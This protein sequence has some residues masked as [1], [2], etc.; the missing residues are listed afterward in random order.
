MPNTSPE[1]KEFRSLVLGLKALN[2]SWSASQIST[3]LRQS[4]NPPL[5]KSRQLL[6]KVK[7]T[8]TRNTI[9][10]RQRPGRPITISTPIF[11]Q[12]VKTSMRLKRGASIR[13]VTANLNRNGT[14]CSTYTVYKAA[15]KLKL[16]WFK[17]R[18][19]QKLSYQ[20]KIDRVDCAKRLRS[21]FGVSRNAKKWKWDR[22]VN[23]DFSGVFILQP[24][25]NNRNDGIWAEENEA[26]PSS[27]INAP[28]DK[29]KKGIIFW[30]AISSN[31]L[32]PVDAPISLTKWLHEKQY[33]VKKN[34]K[35][36][37]TGDLYSKFLIEEAAPAI[38][39]VFENSGATPIFQD[40]QDNKH[41]TTLVKNI[42]ADLFDER[43]DPK[44]GDA[45]FADIWPIE[46][47]W[48][49]I[50]EKVRGQEFDGEVYLEE[51]VAVYWKTFTAEKCRQMMEKIPK[52]LKLVIDKNGE[53]IFND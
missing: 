12:Q 2:S 17:T 34:K 26:I 14:R 53:Q 52:Q 45:K 6:T 49:A 30:G 15:R 5:L 40:D 33:H 43:I 36:Y 39:E 27:L 31:G 44:T 4:E 23:T 41:R 37:L 8:L 22:V 47:V 1:K 48:G 50:K 11:Q 3:F 10:D 46:K 20:N 51:Q 18:K 21:K 13:N 35:M 32:I 19:S 7:R 9:D 16:K 24:F 29:F 25:Q 28:T 42:V 38:Y